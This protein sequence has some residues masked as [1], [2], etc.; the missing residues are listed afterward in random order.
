MK[1][2]LICLFYILPLVSYGQIIADHNAVAD[3]DNIPQKW[4]DEVKK[5]QLGYIGES[6]S[7]GIGIGLNAL[8]ASNAIYQVTVSSTPAANIS[9]YLRNFESFWGDANYSTGW[10]DLGEEDWY[11]STLAISRIK[12]GITYINETLGTP[13][14]VFGFGWCWDPAETADKMPAYV[15]AT[16]EYIQYCI[17]KGY[18][19]KVIFTTGPVDSENASGQTGWNKYLAYKAIRDAV[20][21]DQSGILFDFAD[22]LCYDNNSQTPNTYTW[23]GNTYPIIT[24]TNLGDGNYAHMGSEGVLRLAKAMWWMLARIAGWDG[25]VTTGMWLGGSRG[26]ATDWN[27]A[28]N[29]SGGVV[30]TTEVDV[31]ISPSAT[32]QPIVAASTAAVCKN[33][34]LSSGAA[35][36]IDAGGALTVGGNL[37]TSGTLTIESDATNSGSLIVAGSTAGTVTY[38]RQM[39]TSDNLY[40]YFSSPVASATFPTTGT[41]LT[42]NEVTG[43]WVDTK[44][45]QSGRGYAYKTSIDLL[46]FSGSLVTGNL[47]IPATSPYRY[48]SFYNEGY[49]DYSDRLFVQPGDGALSH[50]GSVRNASDKWGGGGWNLLGN[51]YTSG[52]SV[53]SFIGA[54]YNEIPALSQFD[55]NYV[56]LYLYNGSSYNWVGADIGWP[57]GP[58]LDIRYIQA[59]QGFFVLAMNDA[60]TFT[61]TQAMQGHATDVQLLKSAR[62]EEPWPG[63]QLKVKYSDKESLTTIVYNNEMTIGLDP[64][65]DVGLLSNGPA[66]EIYTVLVKSNGVNFTRQALPADSCEKNIVPVGIDSKQ[67]GEVTFSASTI[68]FRGNKF[69]LEDRTTGIFTDISTKSYTVTLPS[70]TY[71]TGRFFIITS[72]NT[73]TAIN[74][75][76]AE[77]KSVRIWTSDD[78]VII[79]GNVSDRAICTVYDLRG[80]K[81]IESRLTDGELNMVQLPSDLAGIYLVRVV[82]GVKVTSRKVVLL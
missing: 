11:Q 18:N 32:S 45:C 34:I 80:Q 3:F 19:T 29:W 38:N 20:P 78:E 67:G 54:N 51:P 10:H 8:E 41:V 57:T 35:L 53:S 40:H 55:P 22:I 79:K 39:N 56:A 48:N 59:G 72:T 17:S 76:N 14:S 43:V 65:Y 44:S 27:T 58:E 64:G 23:S 21:K 1:T 4:I 69:W 77:D 71:G 42:Y 70:N 12:A 75:P 26:S 25:G 5:M 36:T 68:P 50:T 37:S 46:S 60:S 61:F 81:I 52:L 16:K 49:P 28:A 66:V 31:T 30:P 2:I 63:L 47:N 62:A 6:H 24:T 73:P 13:I 9:S 7:K 33:M 15:N 74:Q 82:D